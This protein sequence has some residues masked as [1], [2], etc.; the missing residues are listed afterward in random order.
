M[1]F[2][3]KTNILSKNDSPSY[4]VNFSH[5]HQFGFKFLQRPHSRD[6]KLCIVKTNLHFHLKMK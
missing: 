2:L 6:T 3:H 1:I 4:L 5:M